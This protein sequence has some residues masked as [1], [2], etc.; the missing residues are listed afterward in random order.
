MKALWMAGYWYGVELDGESEL[1]A[2]MRNF[3]W[4]ILAMN[5][6]DCAHLHC[7]IRPHQRNG[8]HDSLKLTHS[9]KRSKKRSD[10][11]SHQPNW[12]TRS[13]L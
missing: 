5:A 8:A 4:L 1:N 9:T 6:S 13:P 12:E 11:I 2:T 10:L 7:I 3:A